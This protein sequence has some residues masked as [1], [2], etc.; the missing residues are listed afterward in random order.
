MKLMKNVYQVAGPSL[1]H[2][3]DATAYLV[4][5][6]KGFYMIDCGTPEGFERIQE[7]IHS[8]ALNPGDIHPI[9]VTHR[10]YGPVGAGTLWK[11]QYGCNISIH[12][13]GR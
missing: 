5:D 6:E 3:F 12:P 7:N 8:L 9:L 11:A 4:A 2:P 10:H 1:S 13:P